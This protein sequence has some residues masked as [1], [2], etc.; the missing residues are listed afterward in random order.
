MV[1]IALYSNTGL[2]YAELQ[3]HF[4]SFLNAMTISG[5]AIQRLPIR[6]WCIGCDNFE[7]VY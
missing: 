2:R 6:E 7:S 5:M 3:V 4:L 1:F